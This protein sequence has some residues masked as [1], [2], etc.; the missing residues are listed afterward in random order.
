MSGA[1]AMADGPLAAGTLTTGG[2]WTALCTGDGATALAVGTADAARGTAFCV[3]VRSQAA[4]AS[5]TAQATSLR[6][7]TNV[8]RKRIDG[9]VLDLLA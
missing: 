6:V 2:T 3:V 9:S 8:E 5:S 4:S 7:A 1:L